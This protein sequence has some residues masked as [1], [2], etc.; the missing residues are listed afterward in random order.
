MKVGHLL[1]V[2]HEDLCM[3]RPFQMNESVGR[4]TSIK[5][6]KTDHQVKQVQMCDGNIPAG[7]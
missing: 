4:L 1:D 3:N 6:M 2:T 5:H 7:G